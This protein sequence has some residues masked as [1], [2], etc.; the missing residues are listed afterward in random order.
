MHYSLK[1]KVL[2]GIYPSTLLKSSITR[3]MA[4]SVSMSTVIAGPSSMY[5][6]TKRNSSDTFSPS[7]AVVFM[8]NSSSSLSSKKS[9]TLDA[10][11][12]TTLSMIMRCSSVE[13]WKS[14]TNALGIIKSV[15]TPSTS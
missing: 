10:S 5:M 2:N 3:A 6:E 11:G 4:G 12:P 9:T 13:K 8:M 15:S 7:P 14:F 1:N